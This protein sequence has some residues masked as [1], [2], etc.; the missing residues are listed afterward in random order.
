ML[1]KVTPVGPIFVGKVAPPCSEVDRTV[2]DKLS[3]GTA[4]EVERLKK[5]TRCAG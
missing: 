1:R 4:L 5:K 3:G 2:K